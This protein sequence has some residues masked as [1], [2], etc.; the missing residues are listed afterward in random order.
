MIRI[1]TAVLFILMPLAAIAQCHGAGIT[2]LLSEPDRALLEAR[3]RATQYGQGIYWRAQKDGQVINILGTMHLPDPRH[4]TVLARVAPQ[5]AVADLI[6]VE[7]TLDDQ[8]EM[9]I[10]MANNPDLLSIASGPT[11][12][13]LLDDATWQTLRTAAQSR[14]IP[15]FLAAKMQPW[16]LTLSLAIPPCAMGALIEGDLGLDGMIM[17][18][19]ERLGKPIAPLE[20]WQDMFN[21]LRSGTQAEQL[22]MLRSSAMAPDIHDALI[23]TLVN[24]YFDE[25]MALGWNINFVL[26]NFIPGVAADEYSEQLALLETQ[27]LVERNRRWIPVIETAAATH[28]NVFIAFGAAHLIGEYGVLRLLENSGW[29]ISSQ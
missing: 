21:I 3:I 19:V 23:I 24:A 26:S 22:D 2:T 8:A 10:F 9:Q 18:H 29:S 13:E 4:E 25:N 15:G 6:L 11:L 5:L 7:A 14:G 20:P 17:Q 12:P 27:L 28:D 1:L 16:F